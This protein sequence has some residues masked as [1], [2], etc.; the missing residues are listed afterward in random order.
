MVQER[1]ERE[2]GL[3]IVLTAPSVAY[4]I[5]MN[6]GEKIV[7]DNPSEYP[8]PV[9]IDATYEPFIKAE[10]IC[11]QDFIGPIIN[12]CLEKRGVQTSMNYLDEKRVELIYEMPLAEVLFEFYDR[13]KINKQGIR[14]F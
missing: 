11:P 4:K 13:F 6:S 1:L 5:D 9:N 7:I 2:F 14:I 8:D 10:I 3:S 12:L